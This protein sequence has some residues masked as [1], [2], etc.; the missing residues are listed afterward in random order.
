MLISLL[1]NK[2]IK[3]TI[4]K[5]IECLDKKQPIKKHKKINYFTGYF[6]FLSNNYLIPV[7]HDGIIFQSVLHV[8]YENK[9]EDKNIP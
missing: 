6:T 8:Y 4:F 7:Y 1:K 5:T 2:E 9:K 3:E